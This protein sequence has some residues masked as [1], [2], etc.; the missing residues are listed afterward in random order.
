MVL[1]FRRCVA[2]LALLC[3]VPSGV[4][5]PPFDRA[6]SAPT[7]DTISSLI[8]RFSPEKGPVPVAANA[9]ITVI[10]G[11][12]QSLGTGVSHQR[13][14]ATGADLVRL[15]RTVTRAEADALA[16]AVSRLP[17]VRYAV[18]NRIIRTQVIPTDPLF[19]DTGQWGFKY[20]PGSIE[21]ANFTSAW[22]ITTGSAAQTIGIVDSSKLGRVTLSSFAALSELSALVTDWNAALETL[23]TLANLNGIVARA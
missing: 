11:A 9:R 10:A 16:V 21:G 13:V 7:D 22:D 14:L 19:T 3:A 12:M 17:G 5:A 1:G 6:K 2:A 20:S 18:P 15:D 8:V 4:A 23:E